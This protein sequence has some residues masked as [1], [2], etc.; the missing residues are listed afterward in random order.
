MANIKIYLD[1][2]AYNRPFDDQGQ[3]KIYLESE[4][5]KHIQDLILGGKIDLACSFVNR[6][7]NSRSTRLIS[8][9]A[10]TNF[11]KR[12]KIY[13]GSSRASS[14]RERAHQIID[15]GL[16]HV[17]DAYHVASAIE[18][19]CDYLISTD[20][21]ILHYKTEEIKICSPITFFDYYKEA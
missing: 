4:A 7:E 8:K 9:E 10:I 13:I 14:L 21:H 15:S 2:C 17:R 19:G 18:A 5:K 6:F 20:S 16:K 3:I 11:I 1:N 12:A